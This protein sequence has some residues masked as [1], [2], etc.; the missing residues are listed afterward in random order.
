MAAPASPLLAAAVAVACPPSPR[1][2]GRTAGDRSR[3]P[4]ATSTP[5][6]TRATV[7]PAATIHPPT[8]LPTVHHLPCRRADVIVFDV[9]AAPPVP[10]TLGQATGPVGGDHAGDLGGAE[11]GGAQGG[12]AAGG[13]GGAAGPVAPPPGR[14]GLAGADTAAAEPARVRGAP[15][16]PRRNG[17]L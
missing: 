12:A 10:A 17:R 4:L 14:A 7:T 8:R 16:G 11:P 2:T 15:A 13:G 5:P 6:A 3:P 1:S 9:A